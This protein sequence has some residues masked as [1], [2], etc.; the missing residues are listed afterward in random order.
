[1]GTDAINAA[2]GRLAAN[3]STPDTT[4]GGNSISPWA[5]GAGAVGVGAGVG[6]GMRALSSPAGRIAGQLLVKQIPGMR[7]PMDLHDA[8]QQIRALRGGGAPPAATAAA[9]AQPGPTPGTAE[10]RLA[11]AKAAQAEAQAAKMAHDARAAAAK[12]DMV[13][14]Q[15]AAQAAQAQHDTRAA[16]AKADLAEKKL[17]EPPPSRTTEKPSPKPKP[18]TTRPPA[19]PPVRLVEPEAAPAAPTPETRPID[20]QGKPAAV[21]GASQRGVSKRLLA[22]RQQGMAES[23]VAPTEPERVTGPA[24]RLNGKVYTDPNAKIHA[25]LYDQLPDE[26]PANQEIEHG[27][28]TNKRSFVG[29]DVSESLGGEAFAGK[30]Q[31]KINPPGWSETAAPA[32]DD[33]MARLAAS[34]DV[35]AASRARG[36]PSGALRKAFGGVAGEGMAGGA[37]DALGT[38]GLLLSIPSLP[39][40]IDDAH[41]T[42]TAKYIQLLRRRGRNREADI[43]E[44]GLAPQGP[45]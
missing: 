6:L 21:R 34:R 10:W 17:T 37:V 9:P 42:V 41:Q 25:E 28:Q 29:R 13:Q 5:V 8:Y 14:Q 43:L 44:R 40:Q 18:R 30:P 4:A 11:E 3:S 12:A 15:Q 32:E 33:L 1:M 27:W 39:Q 19:K 36:V 23:R 35:A 24:V 7:V 16:A 38:L 31:I 45:Y 22:Q 20:V 26:I 2:A